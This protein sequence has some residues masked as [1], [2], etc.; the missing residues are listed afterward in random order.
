MTTRPPVGVSEVSVSIR[1]WR[2]VWY[3]V[4]RVSVN[5]SALVNWH[6]QYA[7]SLKI[8]DF[9]LKHVLYNRVLQIKPL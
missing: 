4:V 2:H 1:D 7:L 9:F 3:I 6:I 8:L 5:T